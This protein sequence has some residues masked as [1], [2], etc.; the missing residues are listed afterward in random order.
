MKI[1]VDKT[2]KIYNTIVNNLSKEDQ[3]EI[4]R[5]DF[6]IGIYDNE[7]NFLGGIIFHV[8]NKHVIYLTV[9]GKNHKWFSRD[10]DKWIYKYIF[11]DLKYKK[12][13]CHCSSSNQKSKRFL[14]KYGF[15][16]EGV[17]RHSRKDGGHNFIYGIT[18]AEFYEKR[19]KRYG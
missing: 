17:E 11:K 5:N 7:D 3:Q 4:Y 2:G 16:L 14:D 1:A 13:G 6:T 10:L 8:H 12:I 15:H 9:Y 19:I 18:E